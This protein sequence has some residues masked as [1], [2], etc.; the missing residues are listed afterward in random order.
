[1]LACLCMYVYLVFLYLLLKNRCI[2]IRR[3]LALKFSALVIN[4]CH[5][6]VVT[7]LKHPSIPESLVQPLLFPDRELADVLPS[8]VELLYVLLGDSWVIKYFRYQVL[9]A[10]IGST[11]VLLMCAKIPLKRLK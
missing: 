9:T 2:F 5:Q 4:P 6:V 7:F 8:L 10:G 3:Q 1:M 11:H